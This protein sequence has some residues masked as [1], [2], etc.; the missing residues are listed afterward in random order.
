M[1]T[2]LRG[3]RLG[4]SA[5]T[6]P[7]NANS[8]ESGADVAASAA[9]GQSQRQINHGVLN[10]KSLISNLRSLRGNLQD[11]VFSQ[12]PSIPEWQA[13]YFARL[14]SWVQAGGTWGGNRTEAVNRIKAW[15]DINQTTYPLNLCSLGLTTLPL[16]PPSLRTLY[17]SKNRLTSLPQTLRPSLHFLSVNAN[18][19]TS[20]P[21]NILALPNTC[22]IRI[23]ASHLSEAVRS[24]VLTVMNAPGYDNVQ[25]LYATSG[26]G[27][28]AEARSLQQEVSAWTN[29]GGKTTPVDWSAFLSVPHVHEF[30]K[31]L[32]R[33]RETSQYFDARTK[34]N[35][36]QRVANLL[37]QLKDDAE[38]REMCFDLAQASVDK[39]GDRTALRM[40]NMETVC[41]E[42]RVEAEI[43]AGNLI[44]IGMP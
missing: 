4:F 32:V 27:P 3:H 33:L 5:A 14:N 36:Q 37:L 26:N 25:I 11:V 13:N 34:P 28:T 10:L 44:I 1:R 18:P 23:D 19:L 24:R 20:L 6:S 31:F 8:D 15:F 2:T 22:T 9:R 38:S 17:A 39:C 41:R 21:E 40:L 29:E 12:K 35:L 42:K 7:Q 43:K 30:T 16:L